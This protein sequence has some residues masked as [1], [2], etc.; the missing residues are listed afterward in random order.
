MNYVNETIV[1]FCSVCATRREC[2]RTWLTL[3]SMHQPMVLNWTQKSKPRLWSTASPSPTR[4]RQVYY[5]HVSSSFCVKIS[6]FAFCYPFDDERA[7]WKK[8]SEIRW[9]C[10]LFRF[11]FSVAVGT[12]CAMAGRALWVFARRRYT[13][14]RAEFS[15]VCAVCVGT[16]R[17]VFYTSSTWQR[18]KMFVQYRRVCTINS[19][20]LEYFS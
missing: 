15:V 19:I 14:A 5:F 3:R 16:Q 1:W 18:A 8:K 9:L 7:G 20:A 6:R 11:F 12:C 4:Y 13:A 2:G 10:F 17:N